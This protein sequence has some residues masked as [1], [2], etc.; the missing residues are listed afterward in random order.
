M[1]NPSTWTKT[2]LARLAA[3]PLPSTWTKTAARTA[4]LRPIVVLGRRHR[5]H[6]VTEPV[7]LVQ[8]G[9]DVGLGGGE[10]GAPEQ[11]VE[12]AHLDADRAV[13]AQRPV[14]REAVE[15]VVGAVASTGRARLGLLVGV[16]VDTPDR[17]LPGAQHARGAVLLEERD[18]AP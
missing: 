7:L 3:L 10:L 4:D 18:D 12:G 9:L 13:H 11:R 14:D 17:A 2:A 6:E 5:R 16:D 15:H 8:Q 1:T